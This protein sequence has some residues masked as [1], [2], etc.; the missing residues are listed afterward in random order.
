MLRVCRP[1]RSR[2]L[3]RPPNTQVWCCAQRDHPNPRDRE[4]KN[5]CER[6]RAKDVSR[7]GV[8]GGAIVVMVRKGFLGNARAARRSQAQL[9]LHGVDKRRIHGSTSG[10]VG[11][12][13][14]SGA[15]GACGTSTSPG[16][17]ADVLF[18]RNDDP[19]PDKSASGCSPRAAAH[20]MNLQPLV[21]GPRG[22]AW[23]GLEV[24]KS[25]VTRSH[26]QNVSRPFR[27][28]CYATW[29]LMNV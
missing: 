25:A 3:H 1:F 19:P 16:Q 13:A 20:G 21:V 10:R 18:F 14:L 28:T 11:G 7:T 17:P 22:E 27:Y 23:A 8:A 15:I 26:K 5:A 12:A 29:L 2:A 4:V 6:G 9:R 24:A